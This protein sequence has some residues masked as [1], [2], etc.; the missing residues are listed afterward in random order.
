[1]ALMNHFKRVSLLPFSQ[2]FPFSR[3]TCNI[4]Q[5]RELMPWRVGYGE[6]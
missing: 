3:I 2:I 1:M 6:S 4:E 5:E